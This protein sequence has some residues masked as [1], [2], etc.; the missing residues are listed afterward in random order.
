MALKLDRF[1]AAEKQQAEQ[2]RKQGQ[3]SVALNEKEHGQIFDR[4]QSLSQALSG[5]SAESVGRKEIPA[6]STTS[7]S[8]KIP[9]GEIKRG[10]PNTAATDSANRTKLQQAAEGYRRVLQPASHRTDSAAAL[11]TN[12]VVNPFASN[13]PEMRTSGRL[14]FVLPAALPQTAPN[15]AATKQAVQQASTVHP[16][17]VEGKKRS[18]LLEKATAQQETGEPEKADPRD[19]SKFVAAATAGV[20]GS[21]V[22]PDRGREFVRLDRSR[23]GSGESKSKTESKSGAAVSGR[24]SVY[25]GPLDGLMGGMSG[26]TGRGAEEAQTFTNPNLPEAT[27][28]YE[29]RSGVLAV[30]GSEAENHFYDTVWRYQHYVEQVNK[31]AKL[32]EKIDDKELG[33]IFP[34]PATQRVA[35]ELV[36]STADPEDLKRQILQLYNNAGNVYGNV[37]A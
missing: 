17:F 32:L 12:R 27:S 13:S 22:G 10:V 11:L 28:I 4:N 1:D 21:K 16:E 20:E 24:T 8:P 9:Q 36:S 26:D 15:A 2:V 18:A 7:G 3:D 29:M 23:K 34:A 6:G 25:H 5:K 19:T 30:N 35:L 14:A 37:R 33:K 31:Y